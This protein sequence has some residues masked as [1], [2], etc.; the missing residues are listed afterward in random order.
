M[1]CLNLHGKIIFL[2]CILYCKILCAALP[3]KPLTS[4]KELKTALESIYQDNRYTFVCQEPFNE[5]AQI[6]IKICPHCKKIAHKIHWMPIVSLKHI[7]KNSRCYNEKSCINKE[8]RL[9]KG[10][11]CCLE[12]DHNF[13][14]ASRDLHNFVAEQKTIISLRRHFA[15]SS[16][17][18]EPETT[19]MCQLLTDD[20]KHLIHTPHHI[21]GMVARAYLYMRSTYFLPL[22]DE[23]L[24]RYQS[25][26]QQYPPT[27]WEKERNEKIGKIQGN[28]NPYIN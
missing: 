19:N 4:T 1:Q 20:K 21:R 24:A 14:L 23:E 15:F 11:R 26:H 16:L 5:K 10:L 18:D 22:N 13:K 6:N 17:S 25:W 9:Y 2:F 12:Q 7:A 27:A 28:I 3:T 8:G